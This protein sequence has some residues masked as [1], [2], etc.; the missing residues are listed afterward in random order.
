ME[1]RATLR[2]FRTAP[3]KVRLVA[4]VIRGMDAEQA[5]HELQHMT[6]G[7]APAILKLLRSAIAN[8]ENNNKLKKDNL[9]IKTIFVDEGPTLKRWQPRAYGRAGILR[10]RSSHLTIILEER[11]PTTPKKAAD[12]KKETP[13]AAADSK[14]VKEEKPDQ[15]VVPIDEIKHEAK[16][17]EESKPYSGEEKKKTGRGF[18]GLKDKFSRRLGEK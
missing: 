2:Y 1:T 7:S 9:Y 16:G 15:P 8:A 17:K 10:K 4:N 5:E 18:K 6:K 13:K 14:K 12:K 11:D 3:R